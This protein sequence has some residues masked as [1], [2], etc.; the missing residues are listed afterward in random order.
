MVQQCRVIERRKAVR[1]AVF[2]ATGGLGRLLVEQA[3]TQGHAVT[4]FVRNP[5]AVTIQHE[6]LALIQGDVREPAQ[7]AVAVAGQDAIIIALGTRPGAPTG[8]FYSDSTRI[9]V[10]AMRVASA[11]RLVCVSSW[12][13]RETRRRAGPVGALVVPL[14]P[15]RLYADRERQEQIVRDSGFD[16][17]I[18]RPARLVDRPPRGV[19]R[20]GPAISMRIL[21]GISRADVAEFVL[22]QVH[23]NIYLHQAVSVSY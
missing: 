16:W 12:V 9:I 18:V 11:R 7:V 8:T 5:A 10:G 1:I 20:S 17:I 6:R 23:D 19:Y 21:V 3:L 2:G 15:G 22:K 4:A 13:V 14:F